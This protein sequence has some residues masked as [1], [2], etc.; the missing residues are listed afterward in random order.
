MKHGF[1]S[2][3]LLQKGPAVCLSAAGTVCSR[4]FSPTSR[5]QVKINKTKSSLKNPQRKVNYPQKLVMWRDYLHQPNPVMR[6]NRS[7]LSL[8]YAK[9]K[10]Y[11]LHPL[12]TIKVKWRRKTMKTNHSPVKILFSLSN[13]MHFCRKMKKTLFINFIHNY[14]EL[15]IYLS[16]S[17]SCEMKR[18]LFRNMHNCC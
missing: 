18:S 6:W 7:K 13:K 4:C 9:F 5:H 1:I 2:K 12:F 17:F 16:F 8:K 10:Q 11:S 3:I 14:W 15:Q